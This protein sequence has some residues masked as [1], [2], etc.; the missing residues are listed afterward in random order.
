MYFFIKNSFK[1]TYFTAL[2]VTHSSLYRDGDTKI[3]GNILG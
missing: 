2:P 1:K 3:T